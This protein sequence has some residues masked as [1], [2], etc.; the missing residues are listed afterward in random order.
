MSIARKGETADAVVPKKYIHR[1]RKADRD[2]YMDRMRESG[3]RRH[4]WLE[5]FAHGIYITEMRWTYMTSYHARRRST[6]L[7]V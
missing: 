6:R 3:N 4:S 5:N 2:V 1:V 7:V